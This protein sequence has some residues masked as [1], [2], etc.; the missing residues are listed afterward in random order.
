MFARI[1]H[2]NQETVVYGAYSVHEEKDGTIRILWPADISAE[3]YVVTDGVI[4]ETVDLNSKAKNAIAVDINA[5]AQEDS[6]DNVLIAMTDNLP[7]LQEVVDHHM[8]T[9]DG[10]EEKVTLVTPGLLRELPYSRA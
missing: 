7:T 1:H 3:T 9:V 6:T 8:E 5:D 2:N 4:T 10:F